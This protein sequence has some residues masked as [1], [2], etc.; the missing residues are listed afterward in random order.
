VDTGQDVGAVRRLSAWRTA[1]R[2]LDEYVGQLVVVGPLAT[3]RVSEHIELVAM[4]EEQ[5]HQ[6]FRDLRDYVRRSH[7]AGRE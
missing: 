3:D 1:A 6:A 2:E 5:A 7:H 4:L